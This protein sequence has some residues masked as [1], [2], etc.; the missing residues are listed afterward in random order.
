MPQLGLQHTVPTLHVVIPQDSLVG[1][2][3]ALSHV[4]VSQV[5][6]GFVQVPQLALQHTS[7]VLHVF[8]P[9]GTLFSDRLMPHTNCEHFCPGATHVPQLALQQTWPPVHVALPHGS[10]G[11]A[12]AGAARFGLPVVGRL[13]GAAASAAAGCADTTPS[14][15]PP[16][17]AATGAAA[18]GAVLFSTAALGAAFVPILA[19]D[20]KVLISAGALEMTLGGRLW[21][22]A[23]SVCVSAGG[24]AAALA[25][26]CVQPMR[27]ARSSWDSRAIGA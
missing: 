1:Y 21:F 24:L 13:L 25:P 20:G 16:V 14:V 12:A 10:S 17:A 22:G 6:P 9:H 11:G 5:S 4:L 2:W 18:F 26:S 23:T 7:P 3:I 8:G 19:A 27:S 15:A